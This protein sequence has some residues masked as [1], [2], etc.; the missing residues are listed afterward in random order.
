MNFSLKRQLVTRFL[1]LSGLARVILRLYPMSSDAI[2]RSVPRSKIDFL[3]KQF[4]LKFIPGSHCIRLGDS[5]D[6]GYVLVD[7]L[8]KSDVCLSFGIG[9]NISFDQAIAEKVASV[10]MFDHTVEQPVGMH[11]NQIFYK[12]GLSTLPSQDF[13]TLEDSIR[14]T[15]EFK[16]L[17]LKIDIEGAEWD[18]FSNATPEQLSRFRQI[19][20]EFHHF[21]SIA[22]TELYE[23]MVKS[24]NKLNSGFN[25]INVHINNWAK[26]ELVKGVPFP[27]VIEATYI[28]KISSEVSSLAS[29]VDVLNSPNN[30]D[31]FEF[32][33]GFISPFQG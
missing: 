14:L 2:F 20:V 9:D 13:F 24:L 25:L 27:D 4:Q 1:G 3:R 6:G 17:I 22:D 29:S 23:K 12:M 28:R 19:T 21:H 30:P 7:D 31:N 10:H 26:Y 18:I 8:S 11:S 33:L 32:E 5:H 16:D 15:G